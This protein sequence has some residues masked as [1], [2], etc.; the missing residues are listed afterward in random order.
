MISNVIQSK[1]PDRQSIR[2]RQYD[3]A[4][5]A[6]YFVTICTYQRESN[7][8]EVKDGKTWQTDAGKIV[9]RT[10][11]RLPWFFTSVSS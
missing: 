9:E 11:N 4:S 5:Q 1:Q 3:Y 7:L 8:A 10:W 2:L 6:A